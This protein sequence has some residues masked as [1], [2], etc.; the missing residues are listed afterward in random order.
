MKKDEDFHFLRFESLQRTNIVALQIRLVK[1][2]DLLSKENDVSDG[3]LENLRQ[4]LEHY[5][6]Y[7][8]VNAQSEQKNLIVMSRRR[9]TKLPIPSQQEEPYHRRYV[10]EETSAMEA[11]PFPIP[12][13]QLLQLSLLLLCQRGRE[14]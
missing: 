10:S 12:P 11:L 2:G 13:W 4:I 7:M 3:D 14:N 8:A 9:I 6:E 1:L 5:G